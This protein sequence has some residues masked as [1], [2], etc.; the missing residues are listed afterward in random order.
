MTRT[1]WFK[2]ALWI[3]YLLALAGVAYYAYTGIHAATLRLP[4]AVID[5]NNEFTFQS[6]TPTIDPDV[7]T[8]TLLPGETP[9]AIAPDSLGY[10]AWDGAERVTILIMGLDYRDWE[11]GEGAPRTDTMILLTIDPLS[12]TAGMLSIP[13]DLYVSI[14]GFKYDRINTAYRQGETYKLPG[15]GAGLAVETVEQ[16]LGAKIDFYAQIEFFAF[17]RLIDEIGGLKVEITEPI[18]VDPIGEKPPRVLQPG[19]V[20]LPG[21]L[22]LAYARARKTEGGDFDRSRRQQQV[23]LAIR[24]RILQFELIPTLIGKAPT[25]YTELAEG[26]NTDM[27]LEQAIRLGILAKDIPVENIRKGVIGEEQ[28]V[29]FT[30]PDGDQVLKPRPD[31]IR[32]VRD[33]VFGTVELSS[34]LA[35]LTGQERVTAENAVVSV[36]N[37]AFAEGLAANTAQYLTNMGFNIPAANIGNAV[38][39]LTFTTII[40]YTGNPYTVQLL[41]ETLG[42][43]KNRVL[44]QYTP[45]SPVDVEVTLGSDWAGSNPLP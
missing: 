16:L 28:I 25:L 11:A 33:Y 34:P 41:A 19:I 7:P 42:V 30:T 5:P 14:P 27:T 1:K 2:P 22:A 35:N 6:P 26:L 38:Q 36:L 18:E 4:F 12:N 10:D 9:V 40:D 8:P 43:Q 45:N 44:L 21:D 29:F 32:E 3:I 37:G 39:T 24:E 20:T 17:E 23:I 15:G 31:A 13:R